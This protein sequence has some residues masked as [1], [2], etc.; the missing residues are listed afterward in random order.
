MLGHEKPTQGL[1][2]GDFRGI[3]DHIFLD[4]S[5]IPAGCLFIKFWTEWNLALIFF[6]F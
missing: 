4:V 3:L 2:N 1:R 6:E 5:I